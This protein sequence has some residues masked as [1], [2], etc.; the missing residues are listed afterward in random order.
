VVFGGSLEVYSSGLT[1]MWR[2]IA[3]ADDGAIWDAAV[4]GPIIQ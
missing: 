3:E 4:G 2:R 1:W